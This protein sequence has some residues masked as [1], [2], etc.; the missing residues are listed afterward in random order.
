MLLLLLLLLLLLR[1]TRTHEGCVR[2]DGEGGEGGS[3]CGRG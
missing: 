2:E 1:P 3:P